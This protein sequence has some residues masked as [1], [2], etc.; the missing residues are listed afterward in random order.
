MAT[1]I[2]GGGLRR[3]TERGGYAPS[4]SPADARRSP[5]ARSSLPPPRTGLRGQ[6]PRSERAEEQRCSSSS[7]R[8]LRQDEDRAREDAVGGAAAGVDAEDE[9][10]AVE[11]LPMGRSNAGVA[12]EA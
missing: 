9:R 10:S 2:L 12:G 11:D 7:L 3:L 4:D 5:E 8:R 1:F 6:S